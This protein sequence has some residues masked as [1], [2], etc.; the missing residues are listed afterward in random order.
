MKRII[1]FLLVFSLAGCASL[2]NA[3]NT[4]NGTSVSPTAVY[5]AANA[6]DAVEVTATNYLKLPK[7][8]GSNGPV[9]RSPVATKQIIPAVRAGRVAR[10]NLETFMA[11]NPGALGPVGLYNALTTATATLQAIVSQYNIGG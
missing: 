8:T 9:C 4:L 7:C 2:T 3:Y 11:Q 6:F 5:V 10:N 1:P